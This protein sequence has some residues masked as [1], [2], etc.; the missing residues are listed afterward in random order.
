MWQK[1]NTSLEENNKNCYKERIKPSKGDEKIFGYLA[2]KR[3][4]FLKMKM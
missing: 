3:F 4:Y 1:K 2:G